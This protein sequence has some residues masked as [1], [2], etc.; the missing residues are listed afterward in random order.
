MGFSF[1]FALFSQALTHYCGDVG[2]TVALGEGANAAG[3]YRATT[4]YGSVYG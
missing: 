4:T 2:A 3:T 1:L